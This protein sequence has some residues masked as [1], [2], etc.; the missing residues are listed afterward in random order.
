MAFK[1]LQAKFK[2]YLENWL[3][4]VTRPLRLQVLAALGLLV[5]LFYVVFMPLWP[6]YSW[7]VLI[8][9]EQRPFDFLLLQ[10]LLL[11]P[12]LYLCRYSLQRGAL[13]LRQGLPSMESLLVLASLAV[14]WQGLYVLTRVYGGRLE[15]LDGVYT[16]PLGLVLTLVVWGHYLEVS[17]RSFGLEKLS[18]AAE[19]P[20]PEEDYAEEIDGAEEQ[21]YLSQ[22]R[23]LV[24]EALARK[25]PLELLTDR[26]A[27]IMVP[28]VLVIGI[29][30]ALSWIYT[31]F[32]QETAWRSLVIILVLSC[33]GAL[34]MAVPFS[35]Q[36]AVKKGCR[37]GVLFRD[38]G[39]L[40]T[41]PEVS[42]ILFDK[43]GTITLGKPRVSGIFTYN[44]AQEYGIATLA[45]A[46][47]A[48]SQEPEAEALRLRAGAAALPE[49]TEIRGNLAD[50]LTARCFRENVRLGRPAFIW[51]YARMPLEA[52]KQ[53]E[54]IYARGEN[55]LC[56][57]V[58]RFFYAVL[59]LSDT[60]R[61]DALTTLT[62]LKETGLRTVIMTGDTK[63]AGNYL[64]RLA[65]AD[66]V[67]SEL[68]PG[69][70]LDLVKSL[71]LGGEVVAVVGD[72][73]NDAPSLA[74]A[75]LGIAFGGSTDNLTR[76]S[77]RVVVQGNE[78]QAVLFTL[79]LGRRTVLIMKR[80]LLL[81]LIINLLFL[82]WAAGLPELWGL[83]VL[84]QFYLTLIMLGG[85]VLVW[86]Y[87]QW[88]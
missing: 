77:A 31:G 16:V 51:P 54:L 79:K 10:L 32:G 15:Q 64:G 49:C 36:R 12:L 23:Q 42:T 61:P 41:A 48:S 75:D 27:V 44:G 69:E 71:Q 34:F 6:E 24:R 19:G 85:L 83:P 66:Q 50:G 86:L 4:R 3:N 62:T 22:L 57:A 56:L 2:T 84:N 76:E 29:I 82:P 78:L 52:Q 26:V 60:L 35:L 73:S 88:L 74:Q 55:A 68:L 30:T 39:A 14:F 67:A 13:A 17:A 8:N 7:L 58:G 21:L 45:A 63:Q 18:Q 9:P 20:L 70:K 37:Q 81:A 38:V 43:T 25:T 28:L 40:E 87:N 46:M 53:L 59:A 47:A 72:W 33:P 80:G 11:L 65:G 1:R 5:L